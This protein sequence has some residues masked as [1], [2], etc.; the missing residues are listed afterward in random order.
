MN[1]FISNFKAWF[2]CL[3]L[4]ICIELLYGVYAEPRYMERT[5]LL[6][7]AFARP[8]LPQR[9]YTW[10]KLDA[11]SSRQWD[12][13]Q[14]GDS[15][16]LHGID[17]RIVQRYL[18]GGVSYLNMSCCAN[19]GYT[20]YYNILKFMLERTGAKIA[21]LHVTPYTLPSEAT[22]GDDGA[23]L[24]GNESIKVFGNDIGNELAFPGNLLR[25][26]SLASRKSVTHD[27]FYLGDKFMR[28]DSP[29]ASNENYLQFLSM[30]VATQGWIPANDV[31]GSIPSGECEIKTPEHFQWRKLNRQTVLESVLEAFA[32]LARDHRAQLVVVF[33]PVGCVVGSGVG[34]ASATAALS[35]FSNAN[36]DVLVPFPLI[37]TWDSEKFLVPAH[38]GNEWVPDASMRLGV[39]LRDVYSNGNK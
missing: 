21:V 33:Q 9:L 39:A 13:V 34:S 7:Y 38:I 27:V 16:G 12:V 4:I 35:R 1:S 14:V 3:A 8:E 11:F 15:S 24:W 10:H 18:P 2:L 26:P 22:W 23:A 32:A 20:G 25:F 6:Q 30:Y 5:N 29:L 28:R 17:P 37:E 31:P 36:P 19:Q